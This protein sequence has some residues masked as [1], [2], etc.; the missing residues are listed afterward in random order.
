MQKDELELQRKELE[1]TRE[2]LARTAAAQ[3]KTEKA[4]NDQLSELI[5][6]RRLSIMPSL[7]LEP[8]ERPKLSN[9]GNG[10]ALSIQVKPIEVRFDNGKAATFEFWPINLLTNQGHKD[11]RPKFSGPSTYTQQEIN[12]LSGLIEQYLSKEDYKLTIRYLDIE[13]IV[14][15]Q[16]LTIESGACRPS[17]A[18]P[19]SRPATEVEI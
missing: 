17:S 6:Q 8:A 9:V 4:L 2:E 11:I 12:E 7:T 1:D 14:Y 16:V 15:E 5:K 13:G 10:T 18:K 3:E 19:F